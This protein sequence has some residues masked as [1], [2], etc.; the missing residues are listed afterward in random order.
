MTEPKRVLWVEDDHA[1]Q[2]VVIELLQLLGYAVEVAS[3]GREALELLE[4]NTFEILVTDIGMPEMNGWQLLET[5][6][7]RAWDEMRI[8]VTSG[9]AHE[10]DSETRA[11]YGVDFIIHKPF[12]LK[13]LREALEQ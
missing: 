6:R 10:L 4:A 13:Q 1:Q 3:N 9:W 8:I 7:E 12:E 2:Q 11:R 5:V